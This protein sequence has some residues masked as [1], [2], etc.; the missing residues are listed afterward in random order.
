[1]TATMTTATALAPRPSLIERLLD[2]WFAVP[3]APTASGEAAAPTAPGNLAD[4]GIREDLRTA[5]EAASQCQISALS[6]EYAHYLVDRHAAR[7][8]GRGHDRG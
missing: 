3:S 4:T 2:R 1:M 7:G 5:L 8:Q 6:A